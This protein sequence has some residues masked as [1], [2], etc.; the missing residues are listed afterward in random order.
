MSNQYFEAP[1]VLIENSLPEFHAQSNR[2]PGLHLSSIVYDL[3]YTSDGYIPDPT[4]L[5]YGRVVE[6]ALIEAYQSHPVDSSYIRLPEMRF[7]GIYFTID[8]HHTRVGRPV[9]IKHTARS[10]VGDCE[11]FTSASDGHKI[12]SSDYWGNWMQVGGYVV[13][14]CGLGFTCLGGDLALVHSRGDYR[15]K[16]VAYR[17]WSRNFTLD[18]KRNI[19]RLITNHAVNFCSTCGDKWCKKDDHE[20]WVHDKF[21]SDY[22]TNVLGL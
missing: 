17:R 1:A 22:T 3:V 13:A 6:W 9:D 14:L 4:L 5:T 16:L 19:W 12:N 11:L 2:S 15:S 7:E 21:K 18:D 8:V 20:P 10:A